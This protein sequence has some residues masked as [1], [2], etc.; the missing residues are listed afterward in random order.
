MNKCSFMQKRIELLGHIMDEEG[1]HVNAAKV[2]KIC[3]AH[4][5]SNRSEL[6][7]FI[8]TRSYYRRLIKSFAKVSKVFPRE[9]VRCSPVYVDE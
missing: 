7:S 2:E 1:T 5:P 4:R 8:G 9:N 6:K 3:Y